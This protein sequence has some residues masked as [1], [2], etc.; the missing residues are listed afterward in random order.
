MA[1]AHSVMGLDPRSQA[2]HSNQNGTSNQGGHRLS[3]SSHTN[4]N[5]NNL[6]S[7]NNSNGHNNNTDSGS[8]SGEVVMLNQRHIGEVSAPSYYAGNSL[9][10]PASEAWGHRSVL[11]LPDQSSLRF[12][13][14][15][16][17]SDDDS[18]GGGESYELPVFPSTTTKEP[19]DV[20]QEYE[21]DTRL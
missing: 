2:N 20:Y 11:S 7:S 8:Q 21:E 1:P 17:D 15:S 13:M 19:A 12:N 5:N 18:Q 6:N 16:D 10:A 14:D 4:N 9:A 3:V